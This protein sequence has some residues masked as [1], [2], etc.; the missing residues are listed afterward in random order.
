MKVKVI[1][2]DMK[3]A[4][5]EFNYQHA[6]ELLEKEAADKPDVL[7]LPETWN[8]GFFPEDNL[9]GYCDHEGAK[10]KEICSKIAAK[11]N[12]NIVAGSVSNLREDG[13]VYNTAYVFD[14]T[15]KCI[16]DYDK[17]HLFTPMG[18]DNFYQKGSRVVT[19]D[20]DGHKCGIIICYDVRFL[21][22]VRTMALE[23]IDILFIPAQWPTKRLFHWTTLTTARAIENQMFVVTCNSCGKAGETVYAG[24]SRILD[25]WGETIAVAGDS[26]EVISGELDF[27]VIEGIR[28]SINVYKDR[29]PEL[30]KVN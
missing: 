24:N 27:S 21:E 19:F 3:F 15:G 14:R 22:L 17:N 28:N 30:Y 23:K 9:P 11:Y 6:A 18:E 29:R 1:Q 8:T 25:P 4:D 26:E 13:K 10:V 7:V 5:P 2:M 16:A 20:L 12:V